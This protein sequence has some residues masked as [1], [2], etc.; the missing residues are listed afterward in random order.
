MDKI[1]LKTLDGE[2]IIDGKKG[3]I[4]LAK[5]EHKEDVEEVNGGFDDL[6]TDYPRSIETYNEALT[7]LQKYY[8]ERYENINDFLA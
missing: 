4:S 2:I 1:I 5:A 8:A 6:P 3:L 7:Y